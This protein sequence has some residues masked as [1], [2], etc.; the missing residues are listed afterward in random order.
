MDFYHP[1]LSGNT[2]GCSLLRSGNVTE[3]DRN[4]AKASIDRNLR[5]VVS[6]VGVG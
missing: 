3:P 6:D 4:G 5:A 1:R 2:A